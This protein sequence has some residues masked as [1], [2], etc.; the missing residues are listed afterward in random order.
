M[1]LYCVDETSSDT[2]G[3]F[4][5]FGGV[6]VPDHAIFELV[7]A[8]DDVKKGFEPMSIPR[9]VEIKWNYQKTKQ[10][11]QKSIKQE[12]SREQHTELKSKILAEVAKKG[13]D[14][15]GIFLYVV[16]YKFFV[17]NGWQSYQMAMNVCFGKFE[18]YL[19]K[20]NQYGIV[21]IDELEGIKTKSDQG[22]TIN[23]TK[24]QLRGHILFYVLNLYE[25]GTGKTAI[26]HIPLILPNVI[27]TLSGLHQINDLVI[28]AFQYY[29][30]YVFQNGPERAVAV[31]TVKSIVRNFHVNFESPDKVAALNC[32]LNIFPQNKNES[33]SD[34]LK[35]A[36]DL[37]PALKQK[38]GEDFNLS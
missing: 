19:A 3:D 22:D 13:R 37:V 29:L 25:S 34:E 10:A 2:R 32:G 38:L 31:E 35:K 20:K 12:I 33:W 9:E 6:S 4:F 26:P 5:V 27:S 14:D 36:F 30:Q 17:N 1:F 15:I 24:N 11:L 8:V 7:K 16:P 23:L 28:G 18:G 21:L